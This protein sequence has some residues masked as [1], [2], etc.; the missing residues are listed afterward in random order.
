MSALGWGGIGIG[1]L[2]K[3]HLEKVTKQDTFG[4]LP[5]HDTLYPTFSS[6]SR[7]DVSVGVVP[8]FRFR[9]ND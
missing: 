9:S 8:L 2:V 1:W 4:G 7:Y 5:G 6:I 3:M